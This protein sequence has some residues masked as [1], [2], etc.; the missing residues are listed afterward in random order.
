M[1]MHSRIA[2]V[3]TVAGV[4]WLPAGSWAQER[5]VQEQA[6]T[7]APVELA[8]IAPGQ[9]VVTYLNGQLT[10]MAQNAPLGQVL[11]A[12]CQQIGAELDAQAEAR[13]PVLGVIGPG[14]AKEVLVS[15]LSDAHVNYVIKRAAEDPNVIAGIAVFPQ[16]KDTSTR[17]PLAQEL[18]G[19]PEGDSA[20]TAP[21][22]EKVSVSQMVELL[23]AARTE[24][25]SGGAFDTQGGNENDGGVDPASGA[26]VDMAAVLQL[27]EEQLKAAGSLEAKPTSEAQ[28]HASAAA[29]DS[30]Q[31]DASGGPVV[32]RRSNR[33]RRRH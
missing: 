10:I 23:E 15:L 11:R 7:S 14:P 27:M 28:T 20:G 32:A 17:H 30:P 3:L 1:S 9:V 2:W 31:A 13:D 33:H 21:V 16:P 22:T 25:A 12:A 8:Q 5:T 24:L 6:T 19:Q 4:L 29:P 26:Q 18:A